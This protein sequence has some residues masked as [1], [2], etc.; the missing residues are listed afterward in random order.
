MKS[1]AKQ[2]KLKINYDH[3]PIVVRPKINLADD[4]VE[5]LRVFFKRPDITYTLL[6]MKDQKYT[7]KLNG[8]STLVQRRYLLWTLGEI[9]DILNDLPSTGTVGSIF[10]KFSKK[11]SF[12]QLYDFVKNHPEFVFNRDIPHSPSLYEICENVVYL[13][14]TLAQNGKDLPSNLRDLVEK[15]SCDSSKRECIYT[16]ECDICNVCISVENF[17]RFNKRNFYSWQKVDGKVQ[18]TCLT[19][20]HGELV[21]MFNTQMPVLK[22]HI[23]VKREQ[24]TFYNNVKDNLEEN[25]MLVHVDYSKHYS[26][27]DQE[28]IQSAYFGHNTFSIF[29]TCF[30]FRGDDEEVVSK[31]ITVTSNATDHSCIAAHTCTMKVIEELLKFTFGVMDARPSFVLDMFL[32]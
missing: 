27:K 28:E 26:N 21:N 24:N 31:N 15:F 12:R 1:L 29:T 7:G 14:K 19:A 6:G 9:V 25:E 5:W 8:E 13:S 16:N 17:E 20:S 10:S 4:E 30:Y 32:I 23:F 2:F 3:Q 22:K 11:I 18:K